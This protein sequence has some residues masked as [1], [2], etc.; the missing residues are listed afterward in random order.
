MRLMYVWF[1]KKYE[2]NI[3]MIIE[4]L[5]YCLDKIIEW[6]NLPISTLSITQNLLEASNNLKNKSKIQI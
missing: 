1:Y 5:D 6:I 4:L 2:L 3:N